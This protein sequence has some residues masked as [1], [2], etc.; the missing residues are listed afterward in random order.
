MHERTAEEFSEDAASA[1]AF[2]MQSKF[3]IGA[4]EHGGDIRDKNVV[5]EIRQE[6]ADLAN[7]VAALDYQMEDLLT[8]ARRCK[9]R[10]AAC[11]TLIRLYGGN[12]A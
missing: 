10:C 7:Y 3:R 5:R 11:S 12:E 2:V 6:V 1:F 4:K 8:K 9:P